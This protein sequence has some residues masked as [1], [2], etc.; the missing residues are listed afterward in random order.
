MTYFPHSSTDSFSLS[1]SLPLLSLPSFLH[2][3]LCVTVFFIRFWLIALLTYLF[4]LLINLLKPAK[5][6]VECL[7]NLQKISSLTPSHWF[8][9]GWRPDHEGTT[10]GHGQVGSGA[11]TPCSTLSF[12][13]KVESGVSDILQDSGGYHHPLLG[14]LSPLVMEF[15]NS[16]L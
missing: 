14:K 3:S 8:W 11:L 9:V 13:P 12:L 6:T 5:N 7:R 10:G 4:T 15:L 2:S 1:L 16:H